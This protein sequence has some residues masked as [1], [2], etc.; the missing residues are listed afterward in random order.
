MDLVTVLN[1]SPVKQ[2]VPGRGEAEPGGTL[3]VSPKE[4]DSLERCDAWERETP[5][6]EEPSPAGVDET[7]TPDLEE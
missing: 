6:N 4:A 5:E 1:V 3:E 7:D 2:S